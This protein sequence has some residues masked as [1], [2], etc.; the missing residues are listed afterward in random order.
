MN[1]E[2]GS[3]FYEKICSYKRNFNLYIDF[4]FNI[5][6]YELIPPFYKS[7]LN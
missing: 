5:D 3:R 4:G 6:G 7:L 1:L 2:G